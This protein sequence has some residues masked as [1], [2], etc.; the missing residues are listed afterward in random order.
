MFLLIPFLML[1][2]TCTGFNPQI[3]SSDS[4]ASPG[5]N[6][7]F[8]AVCPSCT[9]TQCI[10]DFGDGTIISG[11]FN[12]EYSYLASGN[13]QVKLEAYDSSC[14][15]TAYY[16]I[17]IS[18]SMGIE[19]IIN[20]QKAPPVLTKAYNTLGQEIDCPVPGIY[21]EGLGSVGRCRTRVK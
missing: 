4:I 18:P 9:I 11:S 10:W 8:N 15:S 16:N 17:N 13:Y 1:L 19:D 21:W 6:I 7:T 2:D 14:E 20:T 3:K 5:Q 12:P